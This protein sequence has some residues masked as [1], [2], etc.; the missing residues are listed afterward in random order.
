MLQIFRLFFTGTFIG[1]T[2]TT[3]LLL[4]GCDG[5]ASRE[6]TASRDTAV[7]EAN[8]A[9]SSVD[10]TIKLT[11]AQA[12]SN[13]DAI[14]GALETTGRVPEGQAVGLQAA[15][16]DDAL[17]IT[18]LEKPTAKVSQAEW[19]FIKGDLSKAKGALA[20]LETTATQLKQ[21]LDASKAVAE[22]KGAE[23]VRWQKQ[24]DTEAQEFKN[25]KFGAL[26]ISAA[27][28]GLWAARAFGVPGASILADPLMRM[29]AGP[30]L[31][32]IEAKAAEVATTAGTAATVV[33]GSDI[34]RAALGKLDR[35]LGVQ[36]P[37]VSQLLSQVIGKA[38]G[39][40]ADSIEGLFKTVAKGVA[41]DAE[42]SAEADH[43]LVA[44]RSKDMDTH[45]GE[46][47]VIQGLFAA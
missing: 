36:N 5:Q 40:T 18:P 31:K 25:T 34:G 43:Y 44:M 14:G 2:L 6:T 27:G 7:A 39:G 11:V 19:E 12:T 13:L 29:I 16:I 20:T 8:K 35:F 15:S 38:T 33:M 45:L 32:P 17:G 46:P 24:Y 28:V 23:A 9:K 41:I 4:V 47:K 3:P 21:D 1:L 10:H 22:A 42:K 37:E 26:C 30:V